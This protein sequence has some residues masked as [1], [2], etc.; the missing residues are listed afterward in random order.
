VQNIKLTLVLISSFISSVGLC[1]PSTYSQMKSLLDKSSQ[2]D[3]VG[4]VSEVV[5][6]SAPSR[7]IGKPGHQKARDWIAAKVGSFDPKGSGKL[8]QEKFLPNIEAAKSF[9]QKDFDQQLEGKVPTTHPEYQ[10]WL[11]FT[12]HMKLTADSLKDTSA[13][14]LIW[15]KTGINTKKWLVITA[16]YDTISHN[17]QTLLIDDKANMPGANYNGSGVAVLLSLIKV[18]AQTDLNYSVQVVFLDWQGV[19]F[20][21]SLQHAQALK[22]S[23]REVMGVM[24]LEMLGQDTSYFDKTKKT[25]NMSVYYRSEPQEESFVKQLT[26]HGK[27]ITEKVSFEMKPKGF[28]NSDNIRFWEEG[29]LAATFTQNWEEDFNPKFYQTPQDTP[30]TLNH[31]TLYHGYRYLGGAALGM[32]LDITK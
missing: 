6:V 3:V 32:L 9:Y 2:K 14:N 1:A 7:M 18:L 28:E 15:E 13:V 26:G 12:Q 8:I 11:K 24:N 20:L 17:P 30:E 16:H 27:M 19:G 23:G 21:G 31:D 29:F 25:G 4:L 22:R 10:K 5:K